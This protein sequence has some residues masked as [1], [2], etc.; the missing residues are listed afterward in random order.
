MLIGVAAVL[1]AIIVSAFVAVVV[2]T[3]HQAIVDRHWRT[4][5][6]VALVAVVVAAAGVF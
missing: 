2:D 3:L 1:T 5:L 4:C 6:P